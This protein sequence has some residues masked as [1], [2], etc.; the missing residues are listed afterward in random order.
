VNELPLFIEYDDER[1]NVNLFWILTLTGLCERPSLYF[2]DTEM[3]VT[4]FFTE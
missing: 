3:I 1:L 4:H 2:F